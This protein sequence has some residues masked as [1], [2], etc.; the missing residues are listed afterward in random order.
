MARP[1]PGGAGLSGCLRRGKIVGSGR[2]LEVVD[3]LSEDGLV[4]N[5]LLLSAPGH[6]GMSADEIDLTRN[7]LGVIEGF[8]DKAIAKQRRSVKPR[9][10]DLM[11][12]VRAG[13]GE[14]QGPKMVADGGPL[15]ERLM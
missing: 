7:A 9:N 1:A 11:A 2:R 3:D 14:I 10:R 15:P 5:L 4:K 8:G 6:E 12:D 13:F